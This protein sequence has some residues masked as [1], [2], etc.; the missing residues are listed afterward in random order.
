MANFENSKSDLEREFNEILNLNK[1]IEPKDTE[2]LNSN[3]NFEPLDT[4]L[5]FVRFDD[6][7]F[8]DSNKNT[9]PSDC[10]KIY[11]K[12]SKTIIFLI[13]LLIIT[14]F[15]IV[16]KN[17]KVNKD[18]ISNGNN[19]PTENEKENENENENENE[20]IY[21]ETIDKLK[22]K[23]VKQKGKGN[24]NIGFDNTYNNLISQEKINDVYEEGG[25]IYKAKKTQH[26]STKDIIVGIK[27]IS[28]KND[29]GEWT[30]KKNPLLTYE[31][32]IYFESVS[33]CNI[34]KWCDI[35]YQIIVYT[36]KK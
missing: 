23:N 35:N 11:K 2:I 34:Y 8:L 14:L 27:I 12:Y 21:N 29:N 33:R 24:Y 36:M 3:K 32:Q 18:Q 7:S 31:M 13:I 5:S 1:N 30:I 26:I 20:K 17:L 19:K 16:Y 9:E 22:N 25:K 28:N 15:F 4:K 10:K 6:A